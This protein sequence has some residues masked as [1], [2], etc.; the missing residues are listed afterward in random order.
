[1]SSWTHIDGIINVSAFGRTSYESRYILDTVLDHLPAVWGSEGN[2][3][4]YVVTPDYYRM[5]SSHDEFGNPYWK[6]E[7][8]EG[9]CM[10]INNDYI[11]VVRGDLRDTEYFTTYRNF[12]KWL[13]RLSKRIFVDAVLVNIR[14][15]WWPHHHT[16][17]QY[18]VN[19]E[20]NPYSYMYEYSIDCME[21]D[22]WEPN[23]AE[24]LLW[25][26]GVNTDMPMMLAYKY[27]EDE[28]NNLECERRMRL[29][30][31]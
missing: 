26:R 13:C 16:T 31:R 23:W 9:N 30:Y 28:E 21:N 12:Q 24:Y 11:L 2:M 22:N 7:N 10:E 8:H 17:L 27:Y 5:S 20:Y 6:M 3:K 1:M 18:G 4:V 15:D 29:N 19:N 14:G 25:D